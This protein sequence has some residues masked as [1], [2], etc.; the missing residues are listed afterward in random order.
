MKVRPSLAPTA[1]TSSGAGCEPWVSIVIPAF[2]EEARIGNSIEKINELVRR[3]PYAMEV[4][5]VDDGSRD[6]T[7]AIV[8]RHLSSGV[9]L[10]RNP[11][12]QGKGY[13][14]RQGVLHANGEWVLFT[15]ADLSAPIEELDKLLKV[16]VQEGADIVIGSRAVDSRYIEKHQSPFRE[17]GGKFFNR[18]VTFILGLRL[19]DTQC[20]FKLFHRRRT[21]CLFEKQTTNGFGFDPEI[22]FL[23]HKNNL[24]TVEVPVHWSHSEG[25]KVNPMRDGARMVMDLLRVRWNYLLGKYS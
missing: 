2:N 24:R 8:Q 11:A 25:S 1:S 16:A 17:F 3:S 5:V 14:V 22:L 4:I 6:E 18:I 20:G 21:R 9:Q 23:A 13:S 15:D 7:P 19:R 10:V 12:N